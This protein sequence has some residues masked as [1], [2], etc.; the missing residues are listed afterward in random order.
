MSIRW[1]SYVT[2]KPPKGGSET[3]NGRFLSKIALCLKKVCYKVFCVKTV[4]G[5]VVRYSFISLTIRAKMI[6]G[7]ATP[8]TGNFGSHRLRWSE[9]TD[10][11]S[12]FARINSAGTPSENSSIN[13][14][15]KSTT[16]FPMSPR[17]TS[18]VVPKLPKEG[19]KNAKCPKL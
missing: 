2:L 9:I 11:R 10:F 7:G 19:L 5:K 13:T 6:G 4:S 12:L 14:N 8:C 15:R 17:W 1:S 3:Q 16:R 18:Y